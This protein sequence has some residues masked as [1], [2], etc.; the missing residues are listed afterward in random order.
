[1]NI[2]NPHAVV[3][4]EE[5]LALAP[6]AVGRMLG[7]EIFVQLYQG[8]GVAVG[9]VAGVSLSIAL[10]TGLSASGAAAPPSST[11]EILTGLGAICGWAVGMSLAQRAHLRR[12]L[13][14]IRERGTPTQLAVSYALED[15]GLSIDTGRIRYAISYEAVLEVIETPTAWLLQ[16][17]VTT[18]NLPKRAFSGDRATEFAFMERLLAG[19]TPQAQARSDKPQPA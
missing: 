10:H 8:V 3:T 5:T 17:D 9:L 14:A 16:V 11:G 15:Q 7:S 6:A 1:V 12:F 19:M 13:K 4:F 18:F 2:D